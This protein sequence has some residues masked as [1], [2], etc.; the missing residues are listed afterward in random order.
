MTLQEIKE[1]AQII[2]YLALSVSGPLAVLGYLRAKAREQADREYRIYDELDNKF[3]EFQKLAL[4]HD[5]D[6]L[7]VPDFHPALDGDRL[8][9]KQEIVTD[10]IGFALFQRAFLMFHGQ[11]G[12]FRSRQWRGWEETLMRFVERTAVRDAWQLC[13]G[14]YDLEFQEYMNT[15]LAESMSKDNTEPEVVHAF[16]KTGLYMRPDTERHFSVEDQQRWARALETFPGAR[17]AA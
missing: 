16:R 4:A 3:L 2:N 11:S 5:L 13:K 10:G 8:R 7:D 1:I 6:L 15:K 17:K 12:T 9:K 14:R